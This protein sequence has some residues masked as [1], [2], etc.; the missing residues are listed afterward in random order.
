MLVVGNAAAQAEEDSRE[1][2]ELVAADI[3]C[4]GECGVSS[5]RFCT[6]SC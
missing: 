1:L 3:I 5:H 4:V 2:R 6:I